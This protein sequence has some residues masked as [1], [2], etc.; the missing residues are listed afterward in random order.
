MET[1][2]YDCVVV[3]GG[4][5]GCVVANRLCRFS[6]GSVC[7]I[8]GGPD[9]GP[10]D[11][12][13][14]PRDLRDGNA[15]PRAHDWGYFEERQCGASVQAPRGKVIGGCSAVNHCAA[16]WGLPA[17]YDRWAQAGNPG[18]SYH[19]LRPLISELERAADGAASTYRGNR[20]ALMTRVCSGDELANWQRWFRDSAHAAGFSA[21]TDL[22]SPDPVEGVAPLHLNADGATRCNSAF[23]FLD[24]VRG[25]SNLT[26]LA[27]TLADRLI[28][29]AGRAHGLLCTST[30]GALELRAR[31][32]VLCAGTY[33]SPAILL[34]SGVGPAHQLRDLGIAV[35]VDLPGV[36]QNLLEQPGA[37]V[38]FELTPL[39]RT[40][41]AEDVRQSKRLHAQVMLRG[42][43]LHGDSGPDFHIIPHQEADEDGS[44]SSALLAFNLAPRSRGRVSVRGKDPALPPRIETRLLT[45][46]EGHDLAVVTCAVQVARRLA[47]QEALRAAIAA[48]VIPGEG[49]SDDQALRAH[50]QREVVSYCHAAGT[51]KMGPV[52]DRSAV[53]DASGRVHG[54]G[55]VFVADAA[56]MPELP[57]ANPN[58]T[59]ML[60]G[61]RVAMGLDEGPPHL[62]T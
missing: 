43:S 5:A 16:T 57:R 27:D 25:R 30:R 29:H 36:G 24:P 32:F 2:E 33:G 23:A 50:L 31:R 44:V 55:N 17:D 61:L 53:V 14:W 46:P 7:L 37:M 47:R 49:C 60:I 45:D 48:E 10:A 15:V 62:G 59:C 8:E 38:K 52:A 3:G 19:E 4:S 9:F 51:C 11:G 6:G 18:W 41:L 28:V 26:I 22:S 35:E 20:G 13:R 21:F 58:L 12:G 34:R 40:A 42:R 56:I 39:G 54:L 1:R